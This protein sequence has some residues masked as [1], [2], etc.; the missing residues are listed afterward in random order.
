MKKCICK[1]SFITAQVLSNLCY[2][3]SK[4]FYINVITGLVIYE[5]MCF[6]SIN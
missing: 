3:T 5:I 6:L 2:I 1:E 4:L